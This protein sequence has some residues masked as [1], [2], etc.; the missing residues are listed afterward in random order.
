MLCLP[1]PTP[2]DQPG[3]GRGLGHAVL[4]G[5]T[6]GPSLPEHQEPGSA[7]GVVSRRESPSSL[8]PGALTPS[9]ATSHPDRPEDAQGGHWGRSLGL[10]YLAHGEIRELSQ[11]QKLVGLT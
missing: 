5:R 8:Q 6:P 7:W 9:Q 1:L 4:G 10:P 3:P 11:K 2:C